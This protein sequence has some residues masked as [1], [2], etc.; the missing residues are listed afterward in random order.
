MLKTALLLVKNVF[1]GLNK[2]IS[3]FL[4]QVAPKLIAKS[5]KNDS[6]EANLFHTFSAVWV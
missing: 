3:G 2:G 6:Q 5:I 1:F 4:R